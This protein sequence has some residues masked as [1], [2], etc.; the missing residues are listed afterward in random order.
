M[1]KSRLARSLHILLVLAC[2]SA[3]VLTVAWLARL[4]RL[5]MPL[6]SA[7]LAGEAIPALTRAVL[8]LVTIPSPLVRIVGALLLI[9]AVVLAIILEQ[10]AAKSGASVRLLLLV[11]AIWAA[12]LCALGVASFAFVSPLP[13]SEELALESPR[14]APILAATA[15]VDRAAFGFAP[16]PTNGYARLEVWPGTKTT[17]LHIYGAPERVM[18]FRQTAQGCRW[19]AEQEIHAGPKV[20]QTIDGNAREQIVVQY[21]LE[22]VKDFPVHKTCVNYLGR[23]PRWASRSELTRKDIEPLL[24]EWRKE[25]QN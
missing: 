10:S 12:S 21:Q 18:T 4:G 17:R 5:F 19:I 15:A 1:N 7:N 22:R 16:L 24:A 13:H 8:A 23:D 25:Y 20:W 9:G 11:S 3:P 14:A 6:Y 2:A